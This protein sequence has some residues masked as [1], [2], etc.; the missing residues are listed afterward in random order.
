MRL[1]LRLAAKGEGGTRPN[2]P[3]G[4]VVVRAGRVVGR[5]YHHRA[6]E[7]HAEA[8][9]LREAGDRARGATLYVT[10]EP[11]CTHG[12]TPP[13]TEAILRAGI[14][15]V[16][17]GARDPNPRHAGRGPKLLRRAG[18][19]VVEDVLAARCEDLLRPFA[20]WI[21]RGLPYVTL[22][23]GMTLDGRIA[24]AEG[25]S[26][27]ITGAKSRS[28]VQQLRSRVDAVLVGANTAR[29]DDPSLLSHARTDRPAYRIVVTSDGKLPT[30]LRVLI[31]GTPVHTILATTERCT[32]R[33]CGSFEK[34]G[35]RTWRLPSSRV[36][37]VPLRPLL[38]RLGRMGLLHVLCEGGGEL[39]HGLLSGGLVDECWFFLA[40]KILGG[41]AVG[42]IGGAG[43]RLASAPGFSIR[44]VERVGDDVLIRAYPRQ[45]A[46]RR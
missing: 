41:R 30:A 42:G 37:R 8:L 12:R 10:L 18:T 25:R 40:P 13:C 4:A 29:R 38:R 7:P 15:R 46:R 36:G 45:R 31:G 27:W 21:T 20:K 22:K 19:R 17:M 9:A 33:R 34:T 26:R 3:V 39:A 16:V 1:A 32:A 43:W 23:L 28:Q 35:C 24:D 6:G 44:S 5:G 2:P 14:R 11:C